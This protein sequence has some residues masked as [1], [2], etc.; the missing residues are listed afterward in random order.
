MEP[1][2]Q[3]VLGKGSTI[4]LC[5]VQFSLS[6]TCL[7]LFV[8]ISFSVALINTMTKKQH[9]EERASLT[10]VL[11]PVIQGTQG[12]SLQQEPQ[13]SAPYQLASSPS[14]S[15]YLPVCPGMRC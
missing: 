2:H 3:L 6:F 8:L 9:G 1:R 10:Y 7:R 15:Y 14:L 13:R 11:L 4:D 12:S 5:S